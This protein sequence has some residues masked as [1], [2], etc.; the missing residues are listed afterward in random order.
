MITRMITHVIAFHAF[1]SCLKRVQGIRVEL[2]Y[3]VLSSFQT[4]QF[5]LPSEHNHYIMYLHRRWKPYMA[6]VK[7]LTRGVKR[8]TC[9]NRVVLM[10]FQLTE[11]INSKQYK[12]YC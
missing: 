11:I 3:S 12:Q 9:T 5:G 4:F 7:N 10:E 1:K 8:S 6:D 2:L